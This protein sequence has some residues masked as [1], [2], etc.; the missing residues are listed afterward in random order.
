[1]MHLKEPNCLELS[2]RNCR[3][4]LLHVDGF[5]VFSAM[6]SGGSHAFHQHGEVPAPTSVCPPYPGPILIL[7]HSSGLDWRDFRRKSLVGSPAEGT[8]TRY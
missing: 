4:Q 8:A 6:D 7:P 1:M 2:P 5:K 3:G